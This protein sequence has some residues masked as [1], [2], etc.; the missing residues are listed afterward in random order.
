MAWGD[1]VDFLKENK[2]NKFTARQIAEGL[3]AQVT[4][5]TM[6]LKILRKPCYNFIKF[7]KN[8]DSKT[9]FPKH[10]LYWV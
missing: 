2:P 4:P 10:Y 5:I 1:I 6:Q 3:N 8:K 7:K 9:W